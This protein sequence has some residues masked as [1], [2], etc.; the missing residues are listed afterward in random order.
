M[1]VRHSLL[2]VGVVSAL[3][4]VSQPVWKRLVG[5]QPDGTYL[6]PTGQIVRPFGKIIEV[7]DPQRTLPRAIIGGTLAIIAIYLAMNIAYLSVLPLA[8]VAR[9]P[10]IAADTMATVLG[11][12]GATFVS[13]VI[14][15]STF[16]ALNS[17]LLGTPRIGYAAASDGLFFKV[18][19]RLHPTYQITL[20][21]DLDEHLA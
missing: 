3:A 20:P 4:L 12:T 1:R 19:G 10:L 15:L 14:A 11:P 8:Q 9:S 5:R 16:G 2:A 13:L 18:F 7:N 21:R 17:D 6:L